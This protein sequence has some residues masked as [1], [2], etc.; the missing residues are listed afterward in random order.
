MWCVTCLLACPGMPNFAQTA[1]E[2][3]FSFH[4]FFSFQ[5]FFFQIFLFFFKKFSFFPFSFF[6]LSY[7]FI[8]DFFLFVCL[9]CSYSYLLLQYCSPHSSGS[10][11]TTCYAMLTTIFSHLIIPV[12][13]KKR[14]VGMF[15]KESLPLKIRSYF[16]RRS[17]LLFCI[18]TLL[19]ERILPN[20]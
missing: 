2:N 9:F 13:I 15:C 18:E 12:V 14:W 6:F 1:P 17:S 4:L 3:Q 11:G 7:F 8:F 19:V 20:L 5:N 16:A 10:R